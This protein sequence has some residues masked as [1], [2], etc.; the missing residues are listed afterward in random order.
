[1][2]ILGN[3]LRLRRSHGELPPGSGLA[4]GVLSLVLAMLCVLGVLAFHFPEYLSTP[5]LRRGYE[6]ETLRGVMLAALIVSGGLALA[7]LVLD[8]TRWLAGVALGLVAL[9]LLLGGHQVP[10]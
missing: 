3:L 6:V 9:A 8:R 4:A 5:E 10:V 2:Q 7:N 1:M